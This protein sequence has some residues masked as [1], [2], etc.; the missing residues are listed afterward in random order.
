LETAVRRIAVGLLIAAAGLS[1]RTSGGGAGPPILQPGA[2]GEATRTISPEKAVDLS[3]VRHT[4]ADVRFMQ[5]MIGHH[6]QA[7]EM[8]TL[9]RSRTKRE[10]MRLLAR[11]IELS[12][13]DEITL[14]QR[15]L[16]ARGLPVPDAHAHHAQGATLMPG[17]LT[18]VEMGRLE[19][20]TGG[21]FDR[22]FLE[23]MLKHHEGALVMVRELFASPGGGQ[24]SDI[25]AFATD[26]DADQRIEM[27]RM[28][29]ML[30]ELPE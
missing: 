23:L 12:Q 20:A 8:V 14:M 25:F 6:A 28:G 4:A 3:Q 15:W 26:V 19:A 11:R 22:L 24:E 2:P 10:D 13:E 27:A 30:R 17:M 21:E 29:A 7:L 1:C 9:L 5:G 18:P 16:Q